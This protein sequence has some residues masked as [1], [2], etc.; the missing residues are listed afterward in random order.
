VATLTIPISMDISMR[1]QVHYDHKF[2]ELP[3]SVE[4]STLSGEQMTPETIPNISLH[5][6]LDQE[7]ENKKEE[8]EI[9]AE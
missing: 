1:H 8:D 9:A 3:R 6:L 2:S 7:Y 4:S 5:N